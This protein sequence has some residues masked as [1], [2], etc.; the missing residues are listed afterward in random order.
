MFVAF[1]ICGLDIFAVAATEVSFI[2]F[3][4]AFIIP[5]VLM[6]AYCLVGFSQDSAEKLSGEHH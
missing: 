4:V 6:A 2:G 1:I 5:S 3:V